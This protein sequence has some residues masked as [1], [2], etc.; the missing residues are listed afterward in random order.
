MISIDFS[1]FLCG[2]TWLN[3]N[4][5]CEGWMTIA[6]VWNCPRMKLLGPQTCVQLATVIEKVKPRGHLGICFATCEVANSLVG[7]TPN[8]LPLEKPW[9]S[10][11]R[12]AHLRFSGAPKTSWLTDW[13]T[14]PK[15][16]Q[17]NLHLHPNLSRKLSQTNPNPTSNLEGTF[18]TLQL[19]LTNL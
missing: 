9:G 17:T 11:E 16:S 2:L 14:T 7:E 15:P 13:G 5:I 19:S 3:R 10:A 1:C 8:D 4:S 18:Y 6:M 12:T